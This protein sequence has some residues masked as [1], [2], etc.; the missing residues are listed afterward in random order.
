MWKHSSDRPNLRSIEDIVP[1][2]Q[3]NSAYLVFAAER[4]HAQSFLL[5]SLQAM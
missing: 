1:T 4:V 5:R 3:N 2:Y